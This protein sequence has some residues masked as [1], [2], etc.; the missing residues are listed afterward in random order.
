[1][2]QLQDSRSGNAWCRD[3]QTQL[4]N[5]RGGERHVLVDAA[6]MCNSSRWLK[7]ALLLRQHLAAVWVYPLNGCSN[8]CAL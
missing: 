4:T 1:M 7:T 6:G 8:R 5:S 2:R 3:S